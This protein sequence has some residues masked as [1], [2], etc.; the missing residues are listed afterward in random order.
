MVELAEIRRR[1]WRIDLVSTTAWAMVLTDLGFLLYWTLVITGALP[2][3]AR[4]AEYADPK[5]TAWNW[6]FLPLDLVASL[7]GLSAVQALRRGSS[8][9]AVQLAMSLSLTAT[10]GGM[11]VVYW[12]QRGQWDPR[13]IGPNLYL[14]LFPLPLL[15]RLARGRLR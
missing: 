14:L 2:P 9:A 1:C 8:A 7:S 3:S 15:G 6:S 11:A 4:F 12:A 5:V 13:W 10:A